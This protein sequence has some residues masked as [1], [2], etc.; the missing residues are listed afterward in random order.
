M[1]IT[2]LAATPPKAAN[3]ARRAVSPRARIAQQAA[4]AL[5]QAELT[6]VQPAEVSAITVCSCQ[7]SYLCDHNAR[8]RKDT[9]VATRRHESLGFARAMQTKRA[10]ALEECLSRQERV[11]R[12]A[13]A[14]VTTDTFRSSKSVERKALGP[15]A[16]W[17]ERQVTSRTAPCSPQRYVPATELQPEAVQEQVISAKE[18]ANQLAALRSELQTAIAEAKRS[19]EQAAAAA[20]ANMQARITALQLQL[21][22]AVEQSVAVKQAALQQSVIEHVRS[23]VWKRLLKESVP[24]QMLALKAEVQ[25]QLQTTL[26]ARD[27]AAALAATTAAAAAADIAAADDGIAASRAPMAAQSLQ[28]LRQQPCQMHTGRTEVVSAGAAQNRAAA[29]PIAALAADSTANAASAEGTV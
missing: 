9:E 27:Q 29:A 21:V 18:H 19:A 14:S 26:A 17:N 20:E 11:S 28:Q 10:L 1:N 2:R 15:A 23:Q 12:T 7:E 25:L 16:A 24:Q 4:L 13:A 3:A 8:G 5:Q 6:A 22:A